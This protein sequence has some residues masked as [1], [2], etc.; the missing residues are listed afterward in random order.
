[1]RTPRGDKDGAALVASQTSLD[2]NRF[3][4]AK[5]RAIHARPLLMF[6]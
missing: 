1:M 6:V 4:Q 5:G 2:P 3:A